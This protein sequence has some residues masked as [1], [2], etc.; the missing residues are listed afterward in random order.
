LSARDVKE[1][2]IFQPYL[3]MVNEKIF[4]RIIKPV[5]FTVLALC[6]WRHLTS[7]RYSGL[8]QEVSNTANAWR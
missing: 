8:Y 6:R 7:S 4:E 1:L 5:L 2:I 3:Q